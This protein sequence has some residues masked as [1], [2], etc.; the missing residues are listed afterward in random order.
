MPTFNVFRDY[1]II[2]DG[3]R[4]GEAIN[5]NKPV[6]DDD[7]TT[8]DFWGP[9]GSDS[10]N[11]VNG[12]SQEIFG[13]W[14]KLKYPKVGA[15][16][17]DTFRADSTGGGAFP[18]VWRKNDGSQLIFRTKIAIEPNPGLDLSFTKSLFYMKV[19]KTDDT[20]VRNRFSALFYS[21][22]GKPDVPTDGTWQQIH[23][24]RYALAAPVRAGIV[25]YQ[26]DLASGT[27]QG[28]WA[29]GNGAALGTELATGGTAGQLP[30]SYDVRIFD[31]HG[32]L[33]DEGS[34]T[35]QEKPG[36]YALGW[37]LKSTAPYFGIG[38]LSGSIF[39]ATWEP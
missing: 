14:L 13:M 23:G 39:A 7:F 31:S 38:L 27:L 24:A 22:P 8:D 16:S 10:A 2:V 30:G 15:G 19:P 6:S 36:A 12:S 32:K 26:A 21:D 20:G 17:G 9:S 37:D 11:F 33:L 34:L 4:Q 1:T 25:V 28:R 5:D 18:E 35:I 3:Y 29:T